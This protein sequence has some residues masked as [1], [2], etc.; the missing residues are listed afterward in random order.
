MDKVYIGNQI[1]TEYHYALFG[2]GYIDLY[3]QEELK[4][5]T[6][7]YYRIYTNN[8]G[9]YYKHDTQ[10]YSL[11]SNTVS[12]LVGVTDKYC[13]RQDFPSILFMTLCFTLIGIWFLNLFTSIIR[14]S[15]VFGG[16]F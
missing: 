9:F 4:G 15:G 6:F 13:Y 8:N 3:N 14:K 7:D 16:L 11:S 10:Y 1:P 2:N 12:T 5:G